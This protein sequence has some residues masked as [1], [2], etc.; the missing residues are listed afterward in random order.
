MTKKHFEDLAHR[1]RYTMLSNK[2]ATDGRLR[3]F[4]DDIIIPF[5]R[6]QNGMFDAGFFREVANL[7]ILPDEL[8]G[9][10]DK[11]QTRNGNGELVNEPEMAI[12]AFRGRFGTRGRSD[13]EHNP[14]YLDRVIYKGFFYHFKAV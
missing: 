6:S 2:R 11:L 9:A 7:D 4:V 12:D 8:L 3:E 14:E 5:C 10:W 1:V 13:K